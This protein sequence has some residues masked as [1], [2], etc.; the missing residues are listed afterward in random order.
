M[1]KYFLQKQINDTVWETVYNPID[2][3]EARYEAQNRSLQDG[4][5][6]RVKVEYINIVYEYQATPVKLYSPSTPE[7]LQE[8]F[9]KKS[10]E[11]FEWEDGC[12]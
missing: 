8:L 1:K 10:D 12:P 9:A 5:R 2:F 3:G 4:S 6:Y 7:R 11:P